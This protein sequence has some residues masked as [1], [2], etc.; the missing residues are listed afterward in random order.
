MFCGSGV[1]GLSV[2][3]LAEKV[4]GVDIAPI[5]IKCATENASTNGLS[6][7]TEFRCGNV[8]GAVNEG[9]VFDLIIANPPLLPA[10][11]ESILEAAVADS[12][13][14]S[15][16]TR[17][18]NECGKYLSKKGRALMAFSDASRIVFDNPLDH[19]RKLSDKAGLSMN[20][21]A[22]KDMVYEVYRILEFRRSM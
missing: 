4:V 6:E 21:K 20:I 16:T 14:M 5:A 9:E 2:A 10:Y 7:K 13:E 3:G 15:I 17:F 8:W 19:V 1:L 12:P 11:P 18:I 22:E